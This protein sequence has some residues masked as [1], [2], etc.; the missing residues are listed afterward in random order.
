MPV[1]FKIS[2]KIFWP[3]NVPYI[4]QFFR[5]ISEPN[6]KHEKET[7]QLEVPLS[8]LEGGALLGIIGG[9]V[10]PGSPNPD[11]ISDPKM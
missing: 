9:N 8:G 5:E 6:V 11:H 1:C 3:C 10:P 4:S 2:V 7:V